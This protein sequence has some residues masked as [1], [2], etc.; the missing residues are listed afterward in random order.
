[1]FYTNSRRSGIFDLLELAA[2]VD[3][4]LAFDFKSKFSS[5]T[6]VEFYL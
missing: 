4:L 6:G 1:V 3:D 5:G 2:T